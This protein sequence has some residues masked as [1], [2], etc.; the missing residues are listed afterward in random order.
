LR[1]SH[2]SASETGFQEP[3][4]DDILD[5]ARAATVVVAPH[6][7]T[8]VPF[9]ASSRRG[10]GV[11]ISLD[12]AGGDLL[13]LTAAHVAC[14]AGSKNR[15]DVR[16]NP[17]LD[18]PTRV[19][20]VIAVHPSL[21]LALIALDDDEASASEGLTRDKNAETGERRFP[22]AF[23]KLAEAPPP[24]GS[25]VAALGYAMGWS[26]AFQAA[27]RGFGKDAHSKR[28]RAETW[29]ELLATHD[30]LEHETDDDRGEDT[31]FDTVEKTERTETQKKQI[32]AFALH[33]SAVASGA[34]G[35]PLI[36]ETGEVFGIH[37]F[38][39]A[40]YGGA[41]DVAVG[42][43]RRVIEKLAEEEGEPK[44]PLGKKTPSAPETYATAKVHA[45]IFQSSDQALKAMC[46][47]LTPT[48]RKA[49][50]L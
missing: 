1:A 44:N 3:S 11:V 5:A 7:K 16:A 26:S 15:V 41:R 25:R 47:E 29:G 13:V 37:S 17:A 4:L 6:A 22:T 14:L 32:F 27:F 35:G 46:P 23:A 20:S 31:V 36:T 9:L 24:L 50:I 42:T 39:D 38:G 33:T 45:A 12:G 21:D 49:W 10:S 18:A 43:T 48:Q 8:R 19:G 34:S 2:A 28:A 40:F 30:I